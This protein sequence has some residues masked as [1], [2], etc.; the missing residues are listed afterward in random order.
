MNI[1]INPTKEFIKALMESLQIDPT[2]EKKLR[3][4]AK[5]LKEYE[6]DDRR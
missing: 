4:M 5:I 3:E 2:L 6:N 1:Q